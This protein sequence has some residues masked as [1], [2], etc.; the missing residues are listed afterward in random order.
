MI[1]GKAFKFRVYPNQAQQAAL[2]IQFGHTRFV[3]NHYC[4]VREG[5]YLDTGAGLSYADCTTDLADILK[6]D[7]PWLKEAAPSG[8]PQA[9]QQALKDLDIAY[10][11]FFTGRAD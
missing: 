5:Y 3:Y 11:N 9:M 4:A 8:H 10:Q 7:H 1:V 6:V 2:A